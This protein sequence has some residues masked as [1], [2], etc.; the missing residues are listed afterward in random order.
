MKKKNCK[1]IIKKKFF[2][3]DFLKDLKMS[4]LSF[5]FLILYIVH[6][7]LVLLKNRLNYLKNSIF[8]CFFNEFSRLSIFL[9]KSNFFHNI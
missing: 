5:N 2:L 1:K 7:M 4:L 8:E 6:K 9:K 3:N